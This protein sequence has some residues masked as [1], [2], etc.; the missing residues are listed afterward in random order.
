MSGSLLVLYTT[1][2]LLGSE[3]GC[4]FRYFSRFDKYNADWRWILTFFI[5]IIVSLI[6]MSLML[7]LFKHRSP[8]ELHEALNVSECLDELAKIYTSNERKMKEYTLIQ[9]IVDQSKYVFPSYSELFTR[10]YF[11]VVLKGIA[12]I[13]LRNCTGAF[14]GMLFS[15]FFLNQNP[16]Y[17]HWF[18]IFNLLG[19]A[20]TIVPITLSDRKLP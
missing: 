1:F 19:I 16:D 8:K 5:P 15:V 17:D 13:S 7:T 20:A 3:I 12:I 14:L 4:I 2:M 6:Q 10:Q 9:T 11:V 18:V